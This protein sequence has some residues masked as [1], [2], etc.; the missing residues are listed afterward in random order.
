M[1]FVL[2]FGV[3]V[4]TAANEQTTSS[5]SAHARLVGLAT[6]FMARPVHVAQPA[7]TPDAIPVEGVAAALNF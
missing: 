2:G 6:K 4:N 7:S 5:S 1:P 3:T